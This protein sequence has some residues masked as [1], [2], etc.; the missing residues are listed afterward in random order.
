MW[1]TPKE[2][3]YWNSESEFHYII[4]ASKAKPGEPCLSV[5]IRNHLWVDAVSNYRDSVRGL[6]D[7]PKRKWVKI[8]LYC[9]LK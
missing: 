6:A 5:L 9:V 4:F 8:T 1:A 7:E 2:C 3:W